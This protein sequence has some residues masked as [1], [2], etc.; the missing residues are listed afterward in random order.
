M[1][2]VI[3]T[4]KLRVSYQAQVGPVYTDLCNRMRF[5]LPKIDGAEHLPLLLVVIR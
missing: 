2:V 5:N 1:I 3:V 4:G